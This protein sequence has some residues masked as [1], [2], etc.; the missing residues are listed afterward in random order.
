MTSFSGLTAITISAVAA[1]SFLIAL[2]LWIAANRVGNPKIRWVSAGFFVMAGKSILIAVA[3]STGF[4][5]HEIIELVDALLDLVAVLFVA[6]PFL[7]R[8]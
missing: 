2:G 8:T 3:V 1:I 7:M 6:A 5:Q 4:L